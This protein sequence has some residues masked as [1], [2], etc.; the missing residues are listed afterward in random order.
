MKKTLLVLVI[1]MGAMLVTSCIYYVPA[2]YGEYPG[3]PANMDISYF[4]EYLSPH[5]IWV[6]HSPY[7]YVWIPYSVSYG[8]RPYTHGRWI[9]SSYGWT[10][11]SFFDWGW[12]PFHYGRW[13]WDYSLGW[14]WVPGTL[15]GP[16]WVAW[17]FGSV[18]IGWAPLPPDAVFTLGVGI[19]GLPY[20]IPDT[21]WVFVEGRYFLHSG[22]HRYALPVERNYTIIKMTMLRTNIVHRDRMVVNQGLDVDTMSRMTNRKITKYMLENRDEPGEAKVRA[23]AV[24]VYRPRF[25][26]NDNARPETVVKES[27]AK[28]IVTQRRIRMTTEETSETIESRLKEEREQEVRNLEESQNQE[29]RRIEKAKF[30]KIQEA[31]SEKEK[32]RIEQDFEK[33]LEDTKRRHKTEKSMMEKR[34]EQEDKKI[35]V[36]KAKKEAE[37]KDEKKE[38]KKEEKKEKPSKTTS[39]TRQKSS[40]IQKSKIRQ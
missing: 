31:K 14:Y 32:A 2:P 30:E 21:L 22:I 28:D 9:W 29:E 24:A 16:S 26:W 23:D 4:Y 20:P 12:A 37:K 38:K 15:W 5:G 18:H 39:P 19:E 34:H 25:R 11:I 3:Y 8:W 40:G 13:G 35:K 6:N 7:G 1:F 27:E 33:K 17:R 10:W 36:I